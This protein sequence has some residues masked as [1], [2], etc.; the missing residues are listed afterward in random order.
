MSKFHRRADGVDPVLR[1]RARRL[2][3]THGLG[4]IILMTVYQ[5]GQMP[6]HLSIPAY[7]LLALWPWFGPWQRPAE[8]APPPDAATASEGEGDDGG[9]AGMLWCGCACAC[10]IRSGC[11]GGWVT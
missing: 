6:L 9:M 1:T 11:C 10:G 8:D 4:L 5:Q 3:R 2:K 7:L